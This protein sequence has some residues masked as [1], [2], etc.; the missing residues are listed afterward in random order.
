MDFACRDSPGM[1]IDSFFFNL[2]FSVALLRGFAAH[3]SLLGG[4]HVEFVE[5]DISIL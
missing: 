5:N 3:K 1:K 4:G 2:K